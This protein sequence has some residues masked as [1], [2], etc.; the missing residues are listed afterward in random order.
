[1][2]ATFSVQVRLSKRV[3]FLDNDR[4]VGWKRLTSASKLRFHSIWF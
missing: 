4:L 2:L 3:G 1:M